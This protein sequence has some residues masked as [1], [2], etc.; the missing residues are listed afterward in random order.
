MV[1][2]LDTCNAFANLGKK[3][4]SIKAITSFE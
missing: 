1:L 4:A 2:A 3:A